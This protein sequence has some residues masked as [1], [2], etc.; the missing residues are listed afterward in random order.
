[1]DFLPA[2]VPMSAGEF[3]ERAVGECF[4]RI[5]ETEICFEITFAFQ[6]QDGV[7]ACVDGAV[8]HLCEM[9][10][11]EWELG[12]RDRIDERLNEVTLLRD[13]LVI[14]AAERDDAHFGIGA[15]H[16]SDAIAIETGAVND[17]A[18]RVGG[19]IGFY[20]VRVA[21]TLEFDDAFTHFEGAAFF[22][23]E[24]SDLR[25][26]LAI[27][28]DAGGGNAK[29]GDAGD[30]RF[31]FAN[32]LGGEAR[33]VEAVLESALV[34]IFK[35]REFG[36]VASDDHFAAD[37]ILESVLATELD[38]GLAAGFGEPGFET[39]GLVVDARVDDAGVATGLVLSQLLLFFEQE[40]FDAGLRAREGIRSR[41]ADNSAADDG[42]IEH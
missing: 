17:E 25:G 2:F 41:E 9:N 8:N 16:A 42:A 24:F 18:R 21:A 10:A 22:A 6:G 1:M 34:E 37:V 27:T 33:D 29:A 38:H 28:D 14:L 20:V 26:D 13:E 11:E 3:P 15:G 32:L 36:L 31:N 23:E 7:W 4:D 40:D 35:E 19:A 12:I 5:A 39:A 30:A